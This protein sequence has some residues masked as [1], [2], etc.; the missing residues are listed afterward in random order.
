MADHEQ[1]IPSPKIRLWH[2]LPILIILGLA[3]HLLL[4]QITT[5][6]SSWSVI[7][8]MTWWAVVLAVVAQVLS[9][10]GSGYMLH[11]ILDTN[12]ERLSL[13][14]GVLITVAS[15]SIGL[16]AGGWVGGAAATYGWVR[17]E[18]RDSN[19]AVLAGTLPAMLNNVVLVGV[20]LIGTL[21]LLVVHDLTNVQLIEFGIVVLVLSL[22]TVGVIIALRFPEPA[23]RLILWLVGRWAALRRKPFEPQNTINSVEGFILAW[24][25]LRNGKWLRPVL[26]AMANIGFDMLTLYFLFIAAGQNVSLGVLFAGYGLPFILGKMAFMF[27]G[28]VGVIEGSMV[29]FYTSLKVPNPVSVVVIL[30]YRLFSFWLPSLLG[31]VAAAYLGSKLSQPEGK[32]GAA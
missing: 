17:R 23:T 4:P 18:S 20:A 31:F 24:R 6:E 14:K 13:F 2:Y 7:Q 11:I 10:L 30:V 15:Y 32:S 21:Y 9:Y 22:T 27:P 1:Q 8:G 16:V 26:G 28:G 12:Q 25:S 3:V 5:L 19:V 29:A